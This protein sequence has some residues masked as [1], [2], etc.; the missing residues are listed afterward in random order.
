MLAP[1][2][3]NTI[4]CHRCHKPIAEGE[5]VQTSRIAYHTGSRYGRS[6]QAFRYQKLHSGVCPD[7][8]PVRFEWDAEARKADVDGW[9]A[10]LSA[11]NA[12]F[13]IDGMVKTDGS[14]V[15]VQ[16]RYVDEVRPFLAGWVLPTA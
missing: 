6:R 15:S 13:R 11:L 12:A 14:G 4:T 9:I 3:T 16:A 10:L 8:Q 2:T 7:F 1:M 5:V